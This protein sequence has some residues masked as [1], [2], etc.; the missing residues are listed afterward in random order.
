MRLRGLQ[1]GRLFVVVV[2]IAGLATVLCQQTEADDPNEDGEKCYD[3]GEE[4][5]CQTPANQMCD[6]YG[7]GAFC[8]YCSGSATFEKSFCQWHPDETASCVWPEEEETVHCGNLKEGECLAL[9][10][11][12]TK[13]LLEADGCDNADV[14]CT[15]TTYE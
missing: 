7:Y 4:I 8:Y 12:D 6:N 1:L 3:Y 5:N 14:G 15:G 9:G 10:C 11:T 2:L 13:V